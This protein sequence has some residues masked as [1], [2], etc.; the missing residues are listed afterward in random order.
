MPQAL[1]VL[2]G[3]RTDGQEPR[4]R[5]VDTV[6]REI[7]E[8]RLEGLPL[9]RASP[10]TTSS[11]HLRRSRSCSAP[12]GSPR[13]QQLDAMRQE[14]F[15]LMARLAKLPSTISSLHADHDG[16]SRGS[17]EFTARCVA[18][19]SAAP[20]S[21]SSSVT[22]AGLKDVYKGLTFS[23]DSL[24]D[25]LRA[26]RTHDIHV[27]GLFIFG[28][29]SDDRDTFDA[30]VALAEKADLTFAQFVLLTPFPGTVDFEKWAAQDENRGRHVDGVPITTH[31]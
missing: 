3:L 20:W 7:V 10:T 1:L 18:P 29:P 26:F 13:L 2:F 27:L 16:G 30:T 22:A 31:C 24:I 8:L 5:T 4:Q 25:R 9:H 19:T 15:E 28:L 21:A 6:V 11:G 12:L 23:G 14:R 17:R